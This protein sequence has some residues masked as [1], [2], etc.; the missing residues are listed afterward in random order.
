MRGTQTFLLIAVALSA[1]LAFSSGFAD[2]E[3]AVAHPSGDSPQK[4]ENGLQIF[5]VIVL[6][7]RST[8]AKLILTRPSR[9]MTMRHI[10]WRP[11]E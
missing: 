1:P 7:N 11:V 6:R 3:F 8:R 5:G 4:F 2:T 9:F 10:K